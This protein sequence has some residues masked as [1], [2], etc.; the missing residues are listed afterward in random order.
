MVTRFCAPTEADNVP[1]KG[2]E[3]HK[4]RGKEKPS[5]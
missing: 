5:G 3:A 1:E 2:I 4:G